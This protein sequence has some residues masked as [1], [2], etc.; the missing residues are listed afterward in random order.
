MI[1]KKV[2]EN[3]Q[4][5]K[6]DIQK[7]N[8]SIEDEIYSIIIDGSII[9]G[10]F[11]E[12]SSDVDITI[13]SFHKDVNLQVKR[14]L[15]EVIKNIEKKLPKRE[16]PRKPLVY[17]VQWQDFDTIKECGRRKLNDWNPDNI[18]GGY[19]KLWLYTFDSIK[20]HIVIYGQDITCFYTTIEPKYF[21]PIR[22]KRLHKSVMEIGDR[23]SDYEMNYGAIT[24]IKNAWETVRCICISKGLLSIRKNDIFLFCKTYFTDEEDLKMIEDLYYF[25]LGEQSSRLLEGSFRK[26]LYEFTLNLIQRYYLENE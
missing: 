20:H 3:I 9:R 4:Q 1:R 25:F 2:L 26:R 11:V 23:V 24:Q 16:Y 18:P 19:P 15:E 13:T 14:Q 17:D 7:I 21:V 10:D 6:Y 12:E 22:M 8:S 5:L